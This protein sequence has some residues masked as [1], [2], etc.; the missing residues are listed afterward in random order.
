MRA[1]FKSFCEGKFSTHVEICFRFFGVSNLYHWI[2]STVV[3]FLYFDNICCPHL[4]ISCYSLFHDSVIS[5]K[6]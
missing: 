1:P 4:S 6:I 5:L 3:N 2:W